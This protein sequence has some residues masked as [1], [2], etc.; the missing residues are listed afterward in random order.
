MPDFLTVY[1]AFWLAL[2]GAVMGSFL[3]CC[4]WRRARGESVWRGRSHCDV[5][6][7]TLGVPD[8]IPIFGYL[9]ARGRCRYC[10]AE[11]SAESFFT[12][13]ICAFMYAALTLKYGPVPE[14]PMWLIFFA[15]L[16]LVSLI[17][18][19]QRMIPDVLLAAALAVRLMCIPLLPAPL[20]R[21]LPAILAGALS[22]F[23][24]LLV[25]V[26]IM[27][28]ILEKE[29]MGGGDIK[30]FFVLGAYLGWQKNIVAL[31]FSCVLGIAG[32][33]LQQ[34]GEQCGPSDRRKQ[35]G[36]SVPFAPYITAGTFFALLLGDSIIR[37]YASLL[38]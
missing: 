23:L 12:E 34:H 27:D 35:E 19:H 10:G 38:R 28:R 31:L 24:P 20:S 16:V 13:L 8:L 29:T 25:L 17:D 6:G 1:I 36:T 9:F 3:T 11:I 15:V 4:A 5:C 26:L 18:Y 2:L 14:L 7:H 30:L 22:V 21:Q 37:W 32:I 33:L